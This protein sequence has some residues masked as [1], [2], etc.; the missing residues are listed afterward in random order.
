MKKFFL[1][2]IILGAFSFGYSQSTYYNDYSNS[3]NTMNWESV[4]SSL[5]LNATQKQQLSNLNNQ[6]PTY[7]SWN[8]K[9]ANQPEKW[10][11][12]RYSSMQ[13]ILGNDKYKKFKNK[14]YKGQNPVAVY[15]KNKHHDSRKKHMEHK[16]KHRNESYKARDYEKSKKR[17]DGSHLWVKGHR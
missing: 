5:V 8:A 10:S 17:G 7:D 11:S 4:A 1:S 15:N 3:V 2:A 16:S 13:R 14:Y 12:D 9:Y 6:Y